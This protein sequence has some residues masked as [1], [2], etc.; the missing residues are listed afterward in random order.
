MPMD[1]DASPLA[2]ASH[3]FYQNTDLRIGPHPFDLLARHREAVETISSHRIVDRD[4]IG[5]VIH[6]AGKPCEVRSA[7]KAA[8]FVMRHLSDE[9]GL[10]FPKPLTSNHGDGSERLH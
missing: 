1:H 2:Q 8:A 10:S 9:H 7:D 4:H 3:F 5:I 6:A